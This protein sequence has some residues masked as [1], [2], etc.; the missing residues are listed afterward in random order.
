M[1]GFAVDMYPT[2]LELTGL[3]TSAARLEPTLEGF[4]LLPV[5]H[6]PAIHEVAPAAWKTAAFS[7][8]RRLHC[9]GSRNALIL[10]WRLAVPT[11]HELNR[12][13]AAAIFAHA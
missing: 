12:R 1:R 11:V 8:V 4:S 3:T 13:T 2:A 9:V 10:A 7:Q 5:L 6:D